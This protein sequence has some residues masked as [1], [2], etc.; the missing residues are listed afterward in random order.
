M[1]TEAPSKQK[2]A[3]RDALLSLVRRGKL[4]RFLHFLAIANTGL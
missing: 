1:R 2:R 4:S 3:S